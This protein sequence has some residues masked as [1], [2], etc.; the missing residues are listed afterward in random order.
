MLSVPWIVRGVHSVQ[1]AINIAVSEA[2]RR[3]NSA[4][5]RH[6]DQCEISI[7]TIGCRACETS[8]EAVLVVADTALVGLTFECEVKATS[9]GA[10]KR[11]AQQ[12]LGAEF[13]SIPLIPVRSTEN[14]SSGPTE[15]C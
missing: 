2:G 12:E 6:I 11:I 10:A 9:P 15:N 14:R 1:D 4:D 5:S 3:V 7:Q 8:L 13:D